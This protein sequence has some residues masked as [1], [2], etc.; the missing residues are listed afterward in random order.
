VT[1][2]PT[3]RANLERCLD[4]IREACDLASRDPAE[5]RLLAVT[6][7]ATSIETAEMATAMHEA[8]LEVLLGES[9]VQAL[10]GKAADLG[11]LPFPVSLELIGSLQSNKAR[12]AAR[13]AARI[14]SL[15]RSSILHRLDAC[16]RELDRRIPAFLQVNLSGEATKHG[17]AEG[18]VEAALELARGLEGLEIVGFM[19]M[20]PRGTDH[21]TARPCFARCRELRDRLAP[22]LPWLSMGMSGDFRGAIL[23]G[24]THLR[25]GSHLFARNDGG[26]P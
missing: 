20:A 12:S 13:F 21:E 4:E 10:A 1:A 15:D 14:H 26:S 25:I 9:R 2:D 11:D 3:L 5:V 19:T 18:E 16:A 23:E 6:K 17:F 24:A 7:T 8:G 22:D